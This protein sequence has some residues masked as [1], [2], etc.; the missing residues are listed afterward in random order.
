MDMGEE[1]EVQ[2]AGATPQEELRPEVAR[3]ADA[4]WAAYETGQDPGDSLEELERE[5]FGEPRI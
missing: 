2:A 3:A 1:K 5:V 4:A